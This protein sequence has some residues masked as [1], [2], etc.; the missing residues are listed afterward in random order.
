MRDG[1]A[2]ALLAAACVACGDPAAKP[3]EDAS[4]A[5]DGGVEDSSAPRNASTWILDHFA[6]APVT[7]GDF[8]TRQ[9]IETPALVHVASGC[10]A[11]YAFD[12]TEEADPVDAQI[13]FVDVTIRDLVSVDAF[14][15]G[16]VT[17]RAAGVVL[18]LDDVYIE[19]NWPTWVDYATTN[20]DGMVLDASA[21]IYGEDVTIKNWNADGAIDNK[22]PISQ[23]VRLT[24]EGRGN[25]GIRYWR[26]GPHYLVDSQLQNTGGLGD[27][28]ILWFS[29][30]DTATVKI[31]NS[32]FN[33]S[34]TVPSAMIGCDN[35][36]APTLEYLTTDPRT[37]GEMHE[38]FA[39]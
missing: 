19:P 11:K 14:G 36:T 32:T 8:M 17:A 7:T 39:P 2:R 5:I 34:S 12:I 1:R 21:A 25:R 28:T 37:T 26:D 35:G 10:C 30:C 18:Y 27:G 33:G 6:S 3:T 22:A 16:L 31:F 20:K 24:I 15:G 29:N 13:G 9:R 4:A 38:M 23:F